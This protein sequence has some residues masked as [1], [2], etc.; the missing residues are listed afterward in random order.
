MRL[1]CV[2]LPVRQMAISCLPS[3]FLYIAFD[4]DLYLVATF[5]SSTLYCLLFLLY[6]YKSMQY[7]ISKY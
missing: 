6:L 7:M 1:R 3:P 4:S 2:F 5:L